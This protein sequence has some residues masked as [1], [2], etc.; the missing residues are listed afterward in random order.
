MADN[1]S[2]TSSTLH[3]AVNNRLAQYLKTQLID[4][5][6]QHSK[7]VPTPQVMTW[8]TWWQQ[9][10][11]VLLLRGD[12]SLSELPKKVLSDFEATLV[13]EAL[14]QETHVS[15]L[16][17]LSQ[18][19]KKIHQAWLFFNEYASEQQLQQAFHTEELRLFLNLKERYQQKLEEACWWD[20]AIQMQQRLKW[21]KKGHFPA[22]V[23]LH[24]FDELTPY[25]KH[26]CE[27]LQQSGSRIELAEQAGVASVTESLCVATNPVFEAQQAALWATKQLSSTS[28]HPRIAI[29]APDIAEVAPQ[30]VT[31]LDE[32][33]LEREG[34]PLKTHQR[35]WQPSRFYNVSLGQR[36][37]EL[38]IVQNALQTLKLFSSEQA[39][40]FNEFSQW[41]NSAYSVGELMP[42]QEFDAR[43]RQWQWPRFKLSEL[44][45]RVQ[46]SSSIRMPDPLY[47]LLKNSRPGIYSASKVS[48][49]QFYELA[50]QLLEQTEWAKSAANGALSSQAFQQKQAFEQ[51]LLSFSAMHFT[52]ESQGFRGWLRLLNRFVAEQL[53]QPQ[54]Y[55]QA[56]IQIMGM[57]EAG[58]QSF[59]AIWIMGMTSQSWP[60]EAKPNPFLPMKLQRELGVPRADAQR[61]LDYAL[62]LTNRLATSATQVVWSYH[63]TRDGRPMLLSPVIESRRHQ[64]KTFQIESYQT[65]AEQAFAQRVPLLWIVDQQAPEVTQGDKVPGGSGILDAQRKCPLM[66]FFDYRLGARNQLQDVDE[67]VPKNLLGTLVHEVLEHF[68]REVE[69]SSRLLTMTDAE[70]QDKLTALI[71]EAMLSWQ[72]YF[73]DHYL[74]LERQR[75]LTLLLDWLALEKQRPPFRVIGFEKEFL[76]E[77]SGIRFQLKLDRIDEI[78]GDSFI[79]DYKTG[80]ASAK[81]LLKQP[82][83]APQLAVYLH[84]ISEQVSGLGYALLHSDDGV[85]FNTLVEDEGIMIKDRSQ[86]VFAKLAAK[87]DS[88]FE[89]MSWSQFLE[90]L[91]TQISEL[92]NA[93]RCGEASAQFAKEDDLRF[94]GSL[95]ALRLPEV[96]QQM[97]A[98]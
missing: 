52:E 92:A 93:I 8:S 66:A 23:I 33:L 41:L 87:P 32:L 81:D 79:L 57:L 35:H 97:A 68:W 62:A 17:N 3:L 75:I 78:D 11:Q 39:V 43:L 46:A 54:S 50:V 61:E 90:D 85:K 56:P 30:L 49:Q 5:A 12:L 72:Q 18:T 59:D 42:R 24:G 53:H 71:E 22:Q 64:L 65:L 84:A 67:G 15:P 16:L 47:R 36:L 55:A 45:V 4:E 26:W 98:H 1:H 95:L 88:P 19:A 7:V 80:K 29:V 77:I 21:L 69:S 94:A 9:W 63:K 96:K 60:R 82:I 89:G 44:L 70:L 27:Q 10:Q 2:N 37:S 86:T 76:L 6:L 31:A 73:N 20:S 14:L 34:Q 13:W 74:Q 83:E 38:P 91:K 58:G 40:S 28:Q 51:A 25:L 48:L